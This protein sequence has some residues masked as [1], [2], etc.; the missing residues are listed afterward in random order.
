MLDATEEALQQPNCPNLY[1]ALASLPELRLFEIRNSIEFESVLV[2]RLITKWPPLPDHEIGAQAARHRIR[3]LADEAHETMSYSTDF[4]PEGAMFLSGVYVVTMADRSRQLLAE[5]TDWGQRAY[6]LSAP[7]AVLRATY[8][9]FARSRDEWVKWS[10]L[11]SD[12]WDEYEQEREDAINENVG[13]RD[14]LSMM[15]NMLTPAVGA[16]RRA[17]DRTLQKR[18]FVI[19]VEALRMY[20]A[21]HGE[22]PES[23]EKMRPVPAWN[24]GLSR[25]PFNYQRTSPNRAT[26]VRAERY[27]GDTE[28]TIDIVLEKGN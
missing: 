3:V 9:S 8:L 28:T 26:I 13:K 22:L 1:W 2:S 20:A 7:E 18:N 24:D 10:L 25:K 12:L 15:V 27:P 4:G 11:P 19:S 14:V 16:A 23:L 17:G 6:E 21:E 5:S